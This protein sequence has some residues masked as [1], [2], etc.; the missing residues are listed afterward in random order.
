MKIDWQMLLTMLA[1][2]NKEKKTVRFCYTYL[3]TYFLNKNIT[4]PG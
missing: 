4:I 1:N 2:Q 3:F